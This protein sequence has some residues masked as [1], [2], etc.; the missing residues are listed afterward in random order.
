MLFIFDKEKEQGIW[1]KDTHIPLDII[2][3]NSQKQIIKIITAAQTESETI[4]LS[5]KPAKYV[6][7]LPANESLKLNLQI[8]DTIPFFDDE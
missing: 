1:M 3:L 7:E 6:I 2:W 5:Q 4:Y 8:G